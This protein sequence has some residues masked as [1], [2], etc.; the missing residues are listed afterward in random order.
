[1]SL[2]PRSAALA[3]ILWSA[4]S[5]EEAVSPKPAAAPVPKVVH[6]GFAGPITGEQAQYGEMVLDGANLRIEEAKADARFKGMDLS[7]V[8]GDDQA[9]ASQAVTV[10]QGFAG[11]PRLP[12]VVGHF[13]SSCTLAALPIYD[14][15]SLP[16]ISYGSTNDEVGAKSTWTFR[17]PYKNSLQGASLA[18][19]VARKGYKR[20][21][22]V[23]ENEDYGKGLAQTF[24]DAAI[25]AGVE[26]VTE[27]SYDKT[28]TDYSPI[29]LSLKARKPDAVLLAGFY[30]QLSV[31]AKVAREK[32]LNVPLLAGDG[33]GSS[34]SY[35][36][37][38]G[39]A[40]EGTVATGPFLVEQERPDIAAFST[41]FQS[42]F[43][44]PP[45]S[46]AVYAYDATGIALEAT[47][48][49]GAERQGVARALGAYSSRETAYAGLVGPVWF[50]ANG[51]AVNEDVTLAIVEHGKYRVIRD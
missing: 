25:A 29:V 27:A 26:I 48:K 32:G 23:S 28:T 9:S 14:Q 24:R 31:V 20:V 3:A 5:G 39:E 49:G 1:M 19:Y 2:F 11:D 8:T 35:I 33:V 37:M 51:D 47:L 45:D 21:A 44:K 40:A 42:R 38:A 46:W 34:Q 36:E 15:A 43:G 22:I 16:N 7:L 12:I 17:T 30:P 50:D 18:R 6:I 41:K 4:C 10:A 13:N